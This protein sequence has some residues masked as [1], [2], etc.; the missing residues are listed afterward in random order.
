VTVG[1]DDRPLL[2]N[3]AGLLGEAPGTF[4]DLAFEGVTIDLGEG[5]VQAEPMAGS[6]HVGRTNRGL[7]LTGHVRTALADTCG[8]CL[9]PVR[10]P[11]ELELHE[12]FLPSLDIGTGQPL[13]RSLEPDVPRLSDHHEMDL[14]TLV[15]EAIQLAAPIV[16]LCRPDCEGLCPLCGADRNLG[17]HAHPDVPID[18]RLDV[19]R[20]FHPDAEA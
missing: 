16:P 13:D 7:L 4:R 10:V 6:A 9:V 5:L 3:L 2:F 19:L 12:E 15:R 11:L 20:E 1:P 14:E 18:P 17:P 8:R